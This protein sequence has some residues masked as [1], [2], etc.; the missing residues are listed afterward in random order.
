MWGLD[1]GQS[2]SVWGHAIGAEDNYTNVQVRLQ[3]FVGPDSL[4]PTWLVKLGRSPS[5]VV[6]DWMS[7]HHLLYFGEERD[8]HDGEIQEIRGM[9]M[10][11]VRP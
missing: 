6:T 8:G 5:R 7:G 4:P 10:S 3:F 9:R 11:R 2:P 1:A